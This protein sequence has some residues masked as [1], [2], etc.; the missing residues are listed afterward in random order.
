MIRY[1]ICILIKDILGLYYKYFIWDILTTLPRHPLNTS[2]ITFFQ[3]ERWAEAHVEDL[4]SACF[5][6]VDESH[7][8]FEKSFSFGFFS[9]KD[10][11]TCAYARCMQN[12]ILFYFH[13]DFY[14]VAAFCKKKKRSLFNFSGEISYFP[15]SVFIGHRNFFDSKIILRFCRTDYSIKCSWE[16]YDPMLHTG[17]Q[18]LLWCAISR[19][20]DY[21]EQQ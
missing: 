14:F 2:N 5:L 1:K 7:V 16:Y 15:S 4:R 18:L 12:Q 8:S 6:C 17:Q 10:L 11:P 3:Q 9:C 20:T 21:K 13:K 19:K